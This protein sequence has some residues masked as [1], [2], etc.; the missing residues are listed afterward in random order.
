MLRTADNTFPNDDDVTG[1][2]ESLLRLQGVYQLPTET[3]AL[4]QIQGEQTSPLSGTKY[5]NN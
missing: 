1:A 5:Y 2:L 3:M 4:G